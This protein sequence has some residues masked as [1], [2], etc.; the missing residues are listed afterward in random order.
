LEEEK[1]NQVSNKKNEHPS[2][3]ATRRMF[4]QNGIAGILLAK[5]PITR[6]LNMVIDSNI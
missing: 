6:S 4:D 3:I 1:I 5:L 2:Y